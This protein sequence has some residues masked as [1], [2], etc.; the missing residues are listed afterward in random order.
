VRPTRKAIAANKTP[1]KS[2]AEPPVGP[3]GDSPVWG[4]TGGAGVRVGSTGDVGVGVIKGG[5]IIG[6]D[7]GVGVSTEEVGVGENS[8]VAVGVAVDVGEDS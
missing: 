8:I 6:V 3:N 5:G 7:V 1:P 2:N 4:R